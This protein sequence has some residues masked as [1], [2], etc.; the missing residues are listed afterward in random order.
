MRRTFLNDVIAIRQR[1]REHAGRGAVTEGYRADRELVLKR[2]NEALV[3]ELI[4][5]LR[6][7]RHRRPHC[8]RAC[9]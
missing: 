5:M 6:Y 8:F 9:V 1:A 2:L 7:K 3:T 4:C